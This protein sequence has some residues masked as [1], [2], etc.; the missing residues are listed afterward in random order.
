MHR[1]SKICPLTGER[2][3]K[4]IL[5]QGQAENFS[6]SIPVFGDLRQEASSLWARFLRV[7]VLTENIYLCPIKKRKSKFFEYTLKINL[8]Q[9][10]KKK[11]QSKMKCKIQV[12][13]K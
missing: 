13:K 1:I 2:R 5:C 4:N 3:L 11:P 6:K 7:T 10:L 12:S 8:R 9:F